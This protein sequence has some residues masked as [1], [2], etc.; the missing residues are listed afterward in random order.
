M[1]LLQQFSSSLLSVEYPSAADALPNLR[2]FR[3]KVE[4]S[5]DVLK[6]LEKT[7]K[8]VLTEGNTPPVSRKKGKAITNHRRIDP[9]PFDS[10]GIP[11][12][13]TDAEVRDAYVAIL[14][15]LRSI[16]KVCKFIVESLCVELNSPSTTFSSSG[17]R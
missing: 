10:M 5:F 1:R 17:S 15:Q 14:S 7:T 9:L 13:T 2:V 3:R 16:L 4:L 12:P 8:N 6:D 11:V